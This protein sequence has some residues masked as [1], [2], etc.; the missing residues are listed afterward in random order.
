MASSTLQY[1]P[2]T[3]PP[4]QQQQQQQ[5]QKDSSS[6]F[7]EIKRGELNELRQ[8]LKTAS[9]ERDV[10]K[11][12]ASL[13]RIIAYM[14]IGIDVAALFPDVIMVVN[15]TDVIVKK[16]VYLYICHHALTGNNDSLLLLVINTLCLDFQDAN[17]MVRGLALRSLCSLNSQTTF[18]YS[19]KCVVK[20]LSDPSAYVRK[21]GVL[22][23]AKLYRSKSGNGHGQGQDGDHDESLFE[24]LVPKIYGM[25]MD[26]DPQVIVNAVLTLDEMRPNWIVTQP[27]CRHLMSKFKVLNE[28]GQCAAINI[29]MRYNSITEDEMLD[30]LNF[31]DD[32]LKQSNSALV[33][34][35]IKLFLKITESD[36]NIHEQVYERLRDPLI[37]LM[38][39]GESDETAYTVLSHIYL[40]MSRAPT[41]FQRH[42]KYFYYRHSEPLYIKT[43]KLRILRELVCAHNV[44]DIVEEMS[45]Y[46]FESAELANH[47]VESIGHIAKLATHSQHTLNKL[48]QFLDTNDEAIVAPTVVALK[49]YLRMYPECAT[50]V[51]P[52]VATDTRLDE[53]PES[54]VEAK[55][56]VLWMI[57]EYPTLVEDAP[58]I[59]E[60]YF[61]EHFD[62]QP[63]SVKLQLLVSTVR[64]FLGNG[65]GNGDA[66]SSHTGEIYPIILK[67]FKSCSS[68]TCDPEL[69]DQCLYYY[70]TILYDIDKASKLIN[71]KCTKNDHSFIE[72]EIMEFRDKIYEEFNTLSII[73]GK[74]SSSYMRQPG[75]TNDKDKLL[76]SMVVVS[77]NASS[78]VQSTSSPKLPQSSSPQQT[79]LDLDTSTQNLVDIFTLEPSPDMEPEEFQTLWSKLDEGQ[80]MEF[81]LANMPAIEQVETCLANRGIVCLA[82]GS[83]DGLTKLYYHAKQQDDTSAT[84]TATIFL[85]EV[86]INEKT[87]LMSLLFKST[88]DKQL[89]SKLL[90]LFF[91]TLSQVIPGLM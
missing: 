15:T 56:A 52:A 3:Q 21:T 83:V 49:D 38:E 60:R 13:Q 2:Q 37:T 5:Q 88:D 76:A 71:I 10:E 79:L 87:L 27:V 40:L 55:E 36:G 7:S 1:P 58:Y 75:D 43:L 20:S 50:R 19:Y 45:A 70:R 14:T 69:R 85:I 30:F 80:K 78:P 6:Y 53:L 48:M 84:V 32:R 77:P 22:G 47:A 42:Y 31:F 63:T 29:I 24:S 61:N 39:N 82:Y 65:H 68:I 4:Q 90:P 62:K 51:L 11:I 73:Y 46:V 59:I 57:G 23:L 67:V 66:T 44:D 64:L 54:A 9:N 18:E 34:A 28:W 41:L 81:K 72:D 89:H 26:Q 16:L 25:I 86:I 8:Y 12:R 33:L 74:H 17:P 91:S 35:T